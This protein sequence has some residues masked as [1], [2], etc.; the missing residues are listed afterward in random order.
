MSPLLFNLYSQNIFQEAS[1]GRT[2]VVKI[3]WE[4]I[5]NVRFAN[6]TTII[7]ERMENLQILLDRLYEADRRWGYKHQEDEIDYRRQNKHRPNSECNQRRQHR[8]TFQMF[9]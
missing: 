5:N 6:D 3:G 8:A 9:G 4:V 1:Y 2:E 7:A